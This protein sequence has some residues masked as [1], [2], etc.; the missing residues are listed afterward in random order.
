MP[1]PSIF[2]ILGVNQKQFPSLSSLPFSELMPIKDTLKAVFI[3]L[4]GELPKIPIIFRDLCQFYCNEEPI[5]V[6]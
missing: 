6:S 1:F 4:N 3:E 2:R 5:T